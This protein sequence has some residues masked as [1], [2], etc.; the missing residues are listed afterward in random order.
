MPEIDWVA[1]IGRPNRRGNDG[2][3]AAERQLPVAAGFNPRYAMRK[4]EGLEAALA[5]T[6]I[7]LWTVTFRS[8][9]TPARGRSRPRRQ[10]SFGRC[11][12]RPQARQTALPGN[13]I[14]GTQNS[15]GHAK[16]A[17]HVLSVKIRFRAGG[18][19][20]NSP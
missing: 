5:A 12:A 1:A 8:T 3:S 7:T 9:P 10:S 11:E 16:P 4:K 2:P 13:A 15:A 19:A 17:K 6:G 18:P 14:T 20:D